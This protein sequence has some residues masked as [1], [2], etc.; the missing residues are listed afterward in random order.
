MEEVKKTFYFDFM[1]QL[2][3]DINEEE[4]TIQETYDEMD[5]HGNTDLKFMM[6]R[7]SKENPSSQAR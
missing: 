5:R 6:L 3:E 2:Q 1:V 4:K 7:Q